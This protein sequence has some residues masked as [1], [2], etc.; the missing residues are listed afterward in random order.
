MLTTAALQTAIANLEDKLL[1]RMLG[2]REAIEARLDASDQAT[3]L[4][5][6]TVTRV[7]TL[8]DKELAHHRNLTDDQLRGVHARLDN[9][10]VQFK[11]R[12]AWVNAALLAA[13]KA[14]AKQ[15]E[16]FTLASEKNERTVT[17]QLDQLALLIQANTK[18]SDDK[19]IDVKDRV[20]RIEATGSGASGAQRDTH[21]ASTLVIA[22]VAVALSALSAAA[23][24]VHTV[25]K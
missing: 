20:T 19:I 9:I 8:L 14:T 7:P 4:Q 16:A 1:A 18:A 13:E 22:I 25:V 17:K 24:W 2:M 10:Q 15:A 11:E 21:S 23:A 12:D 6:E 5:E 3:R